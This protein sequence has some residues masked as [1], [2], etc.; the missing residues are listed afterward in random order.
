[1]SPIEQT[2][3]GPPPQRPVP[4][5]P[6]QRTAGRAAAP[7]VAEPPAAR[8]PRPDQRPP[9]AWAQ[10][11]AHL[12]PLDPR[13]SIKAKL[14]MLVVASVLISTLMFVVA[15]NSGTQVRIIMIFSLLAS[16]LLTQFL[17]HSMTAPIREMTAAAR[18]MAEGDY[19]RRVRATSRDEVGDLAATFNKMAADLEA[20]DRHRRELVANVSHELRTPIAALHAVLENVVDGV[21]KP[22]P[23]TMV[24]ALEQTDRL[25]RLVAH[26]LDLSKLDDGVVPLDRRE[27]DVEPFL[28]GVLRGLTVDGSTSGGA[29][30]RRTD[31]ALD[32]RV[33]PGLKAV[34]DPERLHQ[35]VANLV[36]NACRH[37][38]ADGTVTVRAERGPGPYGLLLEV[39][40]QGPGIPVEDRIRVFERF[41]RGAA[42][43]AQGPGSDGG[44]GLG[45]A[46]ARWAVDLHGG[47]IGV[48]E[49]PVGCRIQVVLPGTLPA[50]G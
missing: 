8:P 29:T 37:S 15:V 35:V 41:S 31:V 38:P 11:W 20:S 26:L 22:E 2:A 18:A 33:S 45:L 17:A 14:G 19:S 13:R 32:L 7:A 4:D 36:D 27:F 44:T 1:M 43:T 12:R 46:I 40:D 9:G 28:G 24:A 50:R 23:E 49:S 48:V 10:L 25:G 16:L 5:V 42:S 30:K 34:A 47:S 21:V 6:A 3:D 39:A